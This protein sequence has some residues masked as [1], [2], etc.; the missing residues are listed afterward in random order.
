MLVC[1]WR[2]PDGYPRNPSSITRCN[3]NSHRVFGIPN[4]VNAMSKKVAEIKREA[5]VGNSTETHPFVEFM[6][7]IVF[8]VG[9]A[10]LYVLVSLLVTALQQS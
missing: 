3:I 2:A 6:L 1:S 10:V 7:A 9:P 4:E 8:Y 5:K